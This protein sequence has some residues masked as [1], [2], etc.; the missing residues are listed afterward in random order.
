[1]SPER[2]ESQREY[3]RRFL[4]SALP[5]EIADVLETFRYVDIEQGYLPSGTRIR[6]SIDWNGKASYVMADKTVVGT[7]GIARDEK[8]KTI[9]IKEFE[10]LWKQTKKSRIFKRRYFIHQEDQTIELDI[11]KANLD[12]KMLAEVEF[13][14]H[15]GALAF[16]AFDW[17]GRE[18]TREI[19]NRKLALGMPFPE[20]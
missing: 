16:N 7:D 12:G 3:E 17:F 1:M 13:E 10:K 20:N 2:A 15:E 4:I 19:S 18:V 6:K 9:S 5:S 14:D 8:E 11:F